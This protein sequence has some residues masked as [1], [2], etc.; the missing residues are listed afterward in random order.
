MKI[1]FF[2]SFQYSVPALEALL[3]AGYEITAVVTNPDSFQGRKKQLTPSPVKLAAQ[4]AGL[5]V[6]EPKN[7]KMGKSA[8]YPLE[9]SRARSRGSRVGRYG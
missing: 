8:I 6:I 5:N 4:Q 3:Q 2:G 7:L 1:I 9:N